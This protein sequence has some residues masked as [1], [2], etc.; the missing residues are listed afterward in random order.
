MFSLLTAISRPVFLQPHQFWVFV[1]FVVFI[2]TNDFSYLIVFKMVI[3]E[4][5]LLTGGGDAIT[6]PS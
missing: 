2:V 4:S 1:V 5:G 6:L 3:Q